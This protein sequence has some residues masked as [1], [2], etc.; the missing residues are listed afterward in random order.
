MASL[1]EV[2]DDLLAEQEALDAA[3]N[4]LDEHGWAT[5]TASPR[6]SVA[7]Q[8]GH[9][10][11]F[12]D[13]AALAIT[14]PDGFAA[15]V[16]E[17]VPQLT[18]QLAADVATLGAYRSM[19]SDRLVDEWR[20]SRARLAEASA[21]LG[22]DDR[23]IWYGPSMGSKSFLTARLMECWAHGLDAVA[24]VGR[25]LEPTDRLA[26]IARLGFITRG[27][28]YMNRKLEVPNT[29]VFVRLTAPSGVEWVFGDESADECVIGPAFDF[30]RVVT[31]RIHVDDTD[32]AVGGESAREWMHIA[33]AFAGAPSDGP[34]PRIE[35][36]ERA[37]KG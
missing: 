3:L 37:P 7:D 6:W 14:N 24:A 20:A 4:G 22:E 11:F 8:I 1:G 5:A 28:S 17:L 31:Q 35:S 15:H 18:D 13:T 2:R 33:Q 29:H 30:C 27:W 21:G 19:D 10:G 26:H 12:D 34:V 16:A 25:T 32:L 23:V 9:L 36:P